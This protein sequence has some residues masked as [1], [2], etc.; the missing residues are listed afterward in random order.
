MLASASVAGRGSMVS[1]P[2]LSLPWAY[3]LNLALGSSVQFPSAT[4]K[5]LASMWGQSLWLRSLPLLFRATQARY[6][7]WVI[8]ICVPFFG[9]D[10]PAM[11][12]VL[13]PVTLADAYGHLGRAASSPFRR[14]P[15]QVQH[16][17]C[18][19][20]PKFV[21]FDFAVV[22]H[23]LCC[24]YQAQVSPPESYQ[25][26]FLPSARLGVRSSQ[27]GCGTSLALPPRSPFWMTMPSMAPPPSSRISSS[28][29]MIVSPSDMMILVPFHLM[30]MSNLVSC[31]CQ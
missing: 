18:A 1:A 19:E 28:P 21:D 13:S 10:S 11:L 4:A 22:L 24:A 25:S 6:G 14:P 12:S 23:A 27:S 3:V 2:L 15:P 20:R 30:V 16:A 26:T 9:R 29:S 5:V 17:C 31:V 7:K 8:V